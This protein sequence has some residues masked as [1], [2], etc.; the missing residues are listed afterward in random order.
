MNPV[1]TPLWLTLISLLLAVAPLSA[2][3]LLIRTNGTSQWVHNL[4]S[5]HDRVTATDESSGESIDLEKSDVA[6]AIPIAQRG[7]AYPLNEVSNVLARIAQIQPRFPKLKKQLIQLKQEWEPFLKIDATLAPAVEKAAAD[8]RASQ[9][10]TVDWKTV[11][12]ALDLL[13]YRDVRNDLKPHIDGLLTEFREEYF[14]T[15]WMRLLNLSTQN[16]VR[17]ETFRQALQLTEDLLSGPVDDSQKAELTTAFER[18]RSNVFQQ[19]ARRAQAEFKARPTLANYLS[20][21]SFLYDLRDEVAPS[22]S[23]KDQ[24]SREISNWQSLIQ[25]TT[26]GLTF[27]FEG[28]PFTAEDRR[29][30]EQARKRLPLFDMQTQG[31]REECFLVPLE[32]PAKISRNRPG[33]LKVRAVFN[34][35]PPTHRR[36]VLVILLHPESGPQSFRRCLEVPAFTL[37]VDHPESEIRLDLSALPLDFRPNRQDDGTVYLI[38][39]PAEIPGDEPIE[40]L[41]EAQIKALGKGWGVPVSL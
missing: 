7:A 37:S 3:H 26:P 30:T 22:P 18:C 20:N 36:Q 40:E 10:T 25:K 34:R 32:V 6:A 17:L 1:K 31:A 12:S 16:V 29:L 19:V 13:K 15:N 9:R 23:L 21:V 2:G 35:T 5:A 28:Y 38:V 4:K 8:F 27:E 39:Y 33:L 24:A 14:A 11:Q 41:D